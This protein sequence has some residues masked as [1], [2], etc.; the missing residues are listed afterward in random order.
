MRASPHS[1]PAVQGMMCAQ[2]VDAARGLEEVVLLETVLF[3]VH[4]KEGLCSFRWLLSPGKAYPPLFR[5]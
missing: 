2:V 1:S 3:L 5:P 4:T